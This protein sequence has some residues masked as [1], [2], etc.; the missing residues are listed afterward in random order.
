MS[1]NSDYDVEAKGA[2]RTP[3]SK[4]SDSADYI[5]D[6]S[7]ITAET[8]ILGDSYYARAQRWAGKFG[9][10]ARG[11]ERVPDNERSDAGMSQIGTLVGISSSE[12]LN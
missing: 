2:A 3:F 1:K 6:V 12:R 4:E 10:E 9:V 5:G 11:I 8:L 7:P